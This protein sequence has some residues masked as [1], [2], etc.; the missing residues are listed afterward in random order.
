MKIPVSQQELE[1]ILKMVC[2]AKDSLALS[3]SLLEKLVNELEESFLAVDETKGQPLSREV[4]RIGAAMWQLNV[5]LYRMR[6]NRE[7][8]VVAESDP[9]S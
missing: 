5:I 8:V 3:A 1:D 2:N 9:T 4:T 6:D 7:R